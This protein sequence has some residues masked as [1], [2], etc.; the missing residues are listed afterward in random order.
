MYLICPNCSASLCQKIRRN[1]TK[2]LWLVPQAWS[3]WLCVPSPV[4]RCVHLWKERSELGLGTTTHW[5]QFAPSFR[6][7]VILYL[8]F[9]IPLYSIHCINFHCIL[10]HCVASMLILDGI[11]SHSVNASFDGERF[12]TRWKILAHVCNYILCVFIFPVFDASFDGVRLHSRKD[13]KFTE[14]IMVAFL[15]AKI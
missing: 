12:H 4:V 7:I 11:K 6:C 8:A 3:R 13:F 1:W 14:S 15:R 10:L 5:K 2:Y 9:C